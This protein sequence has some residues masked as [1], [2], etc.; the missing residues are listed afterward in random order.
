MDRNV[1]SLGLAGCLPFE[2]PGAILEGSSEAFRFASPLLLRRW[3]DETKSLCFGKAAGAKRVAMFLNG[4]QEGHK[5]G[6]LKQ[7]EGGCSREKEGI[8]RAEQIEN[9]TKSGEGGK[10]GKKRGKVR[11]AEVCCVVALPARLR[12]YVP[13]RRA[14]PRCRAGLQLALDV[15]AGV[16]TL[17]FQF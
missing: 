5:F 17:P 2:R 9:E 10:R 3:A 7:G 8:A 4:G 11:C 1:S 14:P 6:D 13:T 12:R 15:D 16:T